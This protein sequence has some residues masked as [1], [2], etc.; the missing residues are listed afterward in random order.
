MR[1]LMLAVMPLVLVSV[2][3]AGIAAARS[4]DTYTLNAKLNPKAEVPPQTVSAPNGHGVFTGVVKE[5]G[6]GGTLT[7]KL[8][9]AG[10]SGPATA[11]HI[12]LGKAG[13]AGP[14]SVPLC[15]PCKTGAHGS[16]TV[17]AAQIK[18][19]ETGGAYINVHTVKNPNG[20]IRG[21]VSAKG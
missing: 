8:T 15:G 12:H 4:S 5:K 17:T 20:E 11:G 7:W 10:L 6:T 9:F 13:K 3:V 18:A 14:V 19:F 1:K 2:V 21:Q 16:V